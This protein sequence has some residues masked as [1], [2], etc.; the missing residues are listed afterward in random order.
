MKRDLENE[1]DIKLLV[2]TF[3]DAVNQDELLSPVFNGFAKVN[4][5]THLPLMYTFWSTVLLG[6]MAYKGQ[7]FPKHV[8][9]PIERHHFSRWVELFTKTIDKLFEGDKAAEAKQKAISIAQV[10]QMK[11]GM[12][13]TRTRQPIV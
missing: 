13:D 3:Y 6:S 7:P 8:S 1:E 12:I 2:N 5:D 4:W 10:F 9:L 11:M